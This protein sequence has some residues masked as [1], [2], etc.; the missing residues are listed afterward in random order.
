VYFSLRGIPEVGP[1][2]ASLFIRDLIDR[3]NLES[4]L[5]PQ[6]YGFSVPIDTWLKQAAEILWPNLPKHTDLEYIKWKFI[7]YC[8]EYGVSP[9]AVE[10]ELWQIGNSSQNMKK[11]REEINAL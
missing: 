1:K 5:T 6:D 4:S 10:E 9:I 2:T 7:F 3:F 11:F 8:L